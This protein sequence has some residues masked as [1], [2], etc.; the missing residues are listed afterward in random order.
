MAVG[1]VTHSYIQKINAGLEA[2][3]KIAVN[4]R[5][6]EI[7]EPTGVTEKMLALGMPMR[8]VRFSQRSKPAREILFKGQVR[9]KYPFLLALSQATTERL[10][11]EAFE[12]AGGR[13]ERRIELIACRNEGES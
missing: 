1:C 13:I 10:L 8:G 6:L 9:H 5:T 4:P 7:L 12:K 11:A 3:A 2:D